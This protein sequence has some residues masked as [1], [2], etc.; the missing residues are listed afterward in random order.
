MIRKKKNVLNQNIKKEP[1][2][3]KENIEEEELKYNEDY[4]ENT[5]SNKNR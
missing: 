4:V 3:E 1:I 5:E 2:I